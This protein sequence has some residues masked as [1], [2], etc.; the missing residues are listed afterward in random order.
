M[1]AKPRTL[2]AGQIEFLNVACTSLAGIMACVF[3][4]DLYRND[5]L[6]AQCGMAAFVLWT[7]IG[8]RTYHRHKILKT[9]SVGTF[10]PFLIFTAVIVSL[11]TMFLSFPSFRS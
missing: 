11:A 10:A 2:T 5:V 3:A 6:A 4:F 7:F 1:K 8:V 9:R